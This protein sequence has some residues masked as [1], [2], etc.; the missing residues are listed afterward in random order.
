MVGNPDFNF[1][2]SRLVE[3]D[4]RRN[5]DDAL[6]NIGKIEVVVLR[7]YPASN[8]GDMEVDRVI[9]TATTDPSSTPKKK[10]VRFALDPKKGSRKNPDAE[11]KD[12]CLGSLN[13]PT[14][15]TT[16]SDDTSCSIASNVGDQHSSYDHTNNSNGLRDGSCG[17]AS[18]DLQ[19]NN[20]TLQGTI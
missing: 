9:P 7:C 2:A 13:Q 19:K 5:V 17:Q 11:H 10:V 4:K 20:G 14:N 16:S 3:N 8:D 18:E 6:T 15:S 1:K 12:L